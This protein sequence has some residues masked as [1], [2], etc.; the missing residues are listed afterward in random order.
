MG[1]AVEMFLKED[2]AQV[3]RRLF[4][5]T[6][7]IFADIGTTPHISLALFDDVD[8]PKLTAVVRDFASQELPFRI[9]FSSIGMFPG[10]ENV[11]FLSP[12]VTSALLAVH[13]RLHSHLRNAGLLC[14]PYYLPGSW[15][16]HCAITMEEPISRSVETIRK[17]HEADVFGE[18]TIDNVNVVRFR[19]VITLSSFR[20]GKGEAEQGRPCDARNVRA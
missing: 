15:V 18:Y 14:H 10:Q 1:Y 2:E 8:V 6:C 4:S 20:F 9:R 5:A 17:I 19:P 16:P 12:V 3:I 13:T 7:S 11:V